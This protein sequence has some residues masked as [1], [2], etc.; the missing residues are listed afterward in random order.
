MHSSTCQS[1]T[2]PWPP[3]NKTSRWLN[4]FTWTPPNPSHPKTPLWIQIETVL[5]CLSKSIAN[6]ICSTKQQWHVFCDW[7][8]LLLACSDIP[9]MYAVTSRGCFTVLCLLNIQAPPL[10]SQFLGCNVC[11]K[12]KRPQ[13]WRLQGGASQ[14]SFGMK[15]GLLHVLTEALYPQYWFTGRHPSKIRDASVRGFRWKGRCIH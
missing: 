4:F 11:V 2:P 9:R 7:Q 13:M 14:T 12:R 15:E 10:Q 6:I 3:L 5:A 1:P 8:R